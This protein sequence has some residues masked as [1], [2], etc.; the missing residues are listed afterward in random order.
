MEKIGDKKKVISYEG[1]C[2][3]IEIADGNL[4]SNFWAYSN[5]KDEIE[6]HVNCND[7]FMW[8]C[9]EGYP[10]GDEDLDD[11]ARCYNDV[12]KR[13]GDLKDTNNATML[14]ACRLLQERPQ[15]AMYPKDKRL[16]PLFDAVGPEKEVGR[17]NPYSPESY[18][19]KKQ[20]E[21]GEKGG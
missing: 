19:E 8:A 9:S 14:W 21:K 15:G 10:L 4:D 20:K 12:A 2:K 11:L 16:W 1:L 3:L 5:G 7:V 13:T 17:G 6:I 18:W